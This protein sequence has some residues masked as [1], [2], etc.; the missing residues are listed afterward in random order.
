LLSTTAT[1]TSILTN[2]SFL[3]QFFIWL[4]IR[5]NFNVIFCDRYLWCGTPQQSNQWN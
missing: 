5:N 4:I 2:P 3:A 1:S